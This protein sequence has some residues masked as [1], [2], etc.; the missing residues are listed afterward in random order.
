M[1]RC[2]VILLALWAVLAAFDV[3]VATA[4][5]QDQT[6]ASPIGSCA[7]IAGLNNYTIR[8]SRL[9]DPFWMLRW[10][11]PSPALLA[12]VSGLAGQTYSFKLVKE[13]S[14]AIEKETWLP[15]SA[16]VRAEF[17]YSDIA[18][19]DC[20]DN[21]LDVVFNIFSARIS[22]TLSTS[23]EWGQKK[24]AAPHEAAGVS[25]TTRFRFSPE[26]GFDSAQQLFAGGRMQAM[27][28]KR[29]PFSNLEVEGLGSTASRF[30]SAALTAQHDSPTAWLGHAEWSLNFRN[31]ATPAGETELKEG[32]LGLQFLGTTRPLGGAVIRFGASM[33]GGF[34]QS[35]FGEAELSA[36]TV[37]S[38]GLTSTNLYAG[39]TAHGRHQALAASYA[40][41][42][43]AMD[44]KFHGDWRKHIGDVAFDLWWP[45][46]DHKLLE[47]EQRLTLGTLQTLRAV[48]A[49][50][51]FF[52]GNREVPL[53]P[54][55][56]WRIR[57]NPVIRS[58]P[59][60]R[61]YRTG[62]GAGAEQ[63]VAY[64]S[65][66]GV[67]VFQRPIVPKEL[68]DDDE[69][70]R[71]LNGA[72][73]SQESILQVVHASKD[74]NFQAIKDGLPAVAAKLRELE[75]SEDAA[76]ATAP[77]A[78]DP[79]FL[80]CTEVLESSS[81]AVE[82]AIKGKPAQAYGWVKELLPGGDNALADVV[83]SCGETL[84]RQL[85]A[86]KIDPGL[87]ESGATELNMLAGEIARR[88]QAISQERASEKAKAD[89]GYVRRT[90]DIIT[91]QMNITSVSPIF[92]FDVAR[93]GPTDQSPFAGNR[94]GIGGGI[95]FTLVSSVSFTAGYAANPNSRPGEGPGAFFFSLTTRNL[96]D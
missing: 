44:H 41:R 60:N 62:T 19:E 70:E 51:R 30:L 69:F 54:G 33:D 80:A 68:T 95:R 9:E 76:A 21:Q 93:L 96:F 47:F 43:G 14:D 82:N 27:W 59:T 40:L 16:D 5:A 91:K 22:T 58:I 84:V 42:F 2:P 78:L 26:A 1:K 13:V 10:R 15:V 71:K 67:T 31:T 85:R 39:I 55:D 12:S 29:I 48:P 3:V 79:H 56:N 24:K 7:G 61:F 11:K 8:S 20:R 64:N 90:L 6:A 77:A 92:V 17:S 25:K 94:Y 46:G 28:D 63:F 18:I 89:I 45:V 75:K 83:S 23:M 57:S 73:V 36:G 49:A 52:G 34:A 37:A 66:T 74:E 86:A 65:T 87:L 53:M 88:F 32:R 50:E 81:F 4:V 35:G 38:S 72:I